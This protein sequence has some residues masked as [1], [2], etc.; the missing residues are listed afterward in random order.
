[1]PWD[2]SYADARGLM[3]MI[4]STS[5]QVAAEAGVAFHPDELYDPETNVRLGAIYIG[6][7]YKKFGGQLPLAAGAFNAGPRAMGRW[8]AQHAGHPM[9]EFVELI[10]FAQTREYV[11]RVVGIYA[12]Y[13][14]LYG[15]TPYELPLTVDTKVAK[16]GPDY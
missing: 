1:S 13:R 12:R 11:K 10:A 7:L 5:A 2:V 8:C 6:S 15:P 14:Y 3:Q 4:P 9:D 16:T